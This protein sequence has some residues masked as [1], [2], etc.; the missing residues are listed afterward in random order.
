MAD[1]YQVDSNTMV[2][3]LDGTS[4]RVS[5]SKWATRTLDGNYLVDANTRI[6][7]LDGGASLVG[8]S[9][10]AKN[11]GPNPGTRTGKSSEQKA[12][13]KAEKRRR[14]A[15]KASIRHLLDQAGLGDLSPF[16]DQWVRDG[17][18]P[19]EITAQLYDP[20]SKAGKVVDKIYPELRLRAE[21]GL[22]FM[23]ID[24]IQGHRQAIERT[25]RLLGL[26]EQFWNTEAQQKLIVDDVSPDEYNA[27]GEEYA[28]LGLEEL[29][30]DP[31]KRA[32]LEA[33]ERY[34]N[35]KLQPGEIAGL[36]FD[37]ATS[38]PSLK[39]RINSVRLD[40]AAGRA[41]YGDLS[42]LEAE[43]LSDVGVDANQAVQGFGQLA[44]SRELFGALDAGEDEIGRADQLGAVFE[45]N[46]QARRRIDERARRRVAAFQQGGGFANTREGFS[47][48]G[49]AR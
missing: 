27:R 44:D 4:S 40:V 24:Q 21:K 17:L 11:V 7:T 25:G 46:S 32:E 1:M 42:K 12:A 41:K 22:R 26:P 2:R 34:Y 15:A 5:E 10:W 49:E 8:S 47:G 20:K 19:D 29:D 35:V 37:T 14:A 18:S 38:L 45:G 3:N 33:F 48:L 6:A 39:K 9:R 36:I 23:S 13:D 28:S 43:R 31:V 30:R 16:I